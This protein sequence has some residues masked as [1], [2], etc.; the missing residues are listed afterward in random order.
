[1]SHVKLKAP[2][3]LLAS[4]LSSTKFLA[5]KTRI[6]GYILQDTTN[7]L[8]VHQYEGDEDVYNEWTSLREGR[9]IQEL[10]ADDPDHREILAIAN[11]NDRNRR[12]ANL[13]KK[14]NSQ[15]QRCIQMITDFLHYTEVEDVNSKCTSI[16]WIWTYLQQH[17][18]IESKGVHFMKISKVV[19]NSD[20]PHQ[21]FYRRLRQE[22]SD[23]LR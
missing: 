18:N 3:V 6:I 14:R 19:P 9:R 22:F 21:A 7:Y 17:Y 12:L 4:G 20:E 5:F 16:E 15:L 23:N 11:E 1:M 8:F 10:H 2:E 13:L